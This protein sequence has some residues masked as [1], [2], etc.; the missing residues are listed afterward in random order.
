MLYRALCN[1]PIAAALL[2]LPGSL[3]LALTRAEHTRWAPPSI[4]A[5]FDVIRH[6]Q[7]STLAMQAVA[8]TACR[9]LHMCSGAHDAPYM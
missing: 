9:A 8:S 2:A 7:Q 4:M 6:R 3:L 1:S 5:S